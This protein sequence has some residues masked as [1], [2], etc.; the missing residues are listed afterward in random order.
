MEGAPHVILT[1]SSSMDSTC[2]LE[3]FNN[4]ANKS[5]KCYEEYVPSSVWDEV[6]TDLFNSRAEKYWLL[7]KYLR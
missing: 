4:S 7:I 3:D 5:I 2:K 1:E 6:R